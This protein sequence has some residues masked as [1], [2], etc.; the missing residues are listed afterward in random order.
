MPLE[1]EFR[2]FWKDLRQ[3]IEKLTHL[4]C[5]AI[6]FHYQFLH[7]VFRIVITIRFLET[8]SL[9]TSNAKT[10]CPASSQ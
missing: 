1:G 5:F 7:T 6:L 2:C 10:W 3:K 8:I 9:S 4:D